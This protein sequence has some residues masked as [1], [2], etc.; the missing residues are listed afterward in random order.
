[1]SEYSDELNEIIINI[2]NGDPDLFHFGKKVYLK[3]NNPNFKKFNS[4]YKVMYKTITFQ[5]ENAPVFDNTMILK[6]TKCIDENPY[7]L[8][9]LLADTYSKV[10]IDPTRSEAFIKLKELE[11]EAKNNSS[12]SNPINSGIQ[13]VAKT[14]SSV[15]AS[16]SNF[17]TSSDDIDSSINIDESNLDRI[18]QVMLSSKYP[19]YTDPFK[20]NLIG[21]RNSNLNTINKFNDKLLVI[22]YDN[23]K[24]PKMLVLNMTTK[25]GERIMLNPPNPAGASI[26]QEGY[27]PRMFK[28]GV[29]HRNS[30]EHGRHEALVD[31]TG[32]GYYIYR[33]NNRDRRFDLIP[34]NLVRT[35][36]TGIHLHRA[37]WNY[38]SQTVD[39]YSA[40]CQVIQDPQLYLQLIE[41]FKLQI[42]YTKQNLF[43]YI[44]TNSSKL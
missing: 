22:Y 12:S 42:K 28:L 19:F 29:H 36:G 14:A 1:M 10:G 3:F 37:G 17:F 34:S 40:G 26:L 30:S 39:N 38:V 11:D 8:N 13:A 33:D 21:V 7:K 6:L 35:V 15:V 9:E 5:Q 41:L 43:D 32:T 27:Y 4:L 24:T 20:L 23:K 44:L 25:P 16:V 31:E 2:T 18:K